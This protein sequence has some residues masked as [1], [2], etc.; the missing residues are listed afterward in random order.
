[1]SNRNK[2]IQT[3]CN[4]IEAMLAEDKSMS[5]SLKKVVK[6]AIKQGRAV[7]GDATASNDGAPTAL[8]TTKRRKSAEPCDA[9]ADASSTDG[10]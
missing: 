7:A 6:E 10:P 3:V 1:M 9:G 4:A 8:K 2:A 5:D